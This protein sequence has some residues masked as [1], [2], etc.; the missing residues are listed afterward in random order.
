MSYPAAAARDYRVVQRLRRLVVARTQRAWAGMGED[1]DESWV[2]VG[3]AVTAAVAAGQ[4]AAATQSATA[5]S[6]VVD[7]LDVDA[8]RQAQ[9]VPGRF[10]GVAADGR[11]LTGLLEGAVS[12]A[13]V[14]VAGGL[15]TDEA[16]AVGGRWMDALVR[17]AVTDA[18]R[19]ALAAG[20]VARDRVG[21]VRMVNPPCCGRCAVLA[22][23]W[24]RWSDGFDRHL[25]CDCAHVVAPESVAGRLT[26]NPDS[27][28]AR[29]LVRGL[30]VRE[31]Q[32]MAEGADLTTVVNESRAMWLARTQDQ[33][34]RRSRARAG[35]TPAPAPAPR[36]S[37]DGLLGQLRAD[38]TSREEGRARL[39]AA[40]FLAA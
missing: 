3:P 38:V 22:G 21:W 28:H 33:R 32:R 4:L 10:A 13:R 17:T 34:S 5:I 26:V 30:T 18:H 39:A 29:G 11:S 24:Y 35:G 12:H 25:Q 36:P 23:R 6:G 8:P 14:A 19:G 7:E 16:L 9:V 20:V 37:L 15:A 31:Q 2:Q 1:F 40:G 27:L